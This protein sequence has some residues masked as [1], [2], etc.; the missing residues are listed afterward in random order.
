MSEIS[1]PKSEP[2]S[3]KQPVE[4]ISKFK[5]STIYQNV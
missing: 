3:I 5:L 1:E 4:N 2:V